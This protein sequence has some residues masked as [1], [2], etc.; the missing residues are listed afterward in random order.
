[1]TDAQPAFDLREFALRA[2]EIAQEN[3]RNDGHLVPVAFIITPTGVEVCDASFEGEEQKAARYA[4][5]VAAAR[6]KDAIAIMTIND[7]HVAKP[8]DVEG[9]Y[10]GK[11]AVEGA[12]ECLWLAVSGPAMET[13]NLRVP[14]Q[15]S[16]EGIVFGEPEEEYGSVNFLPGWP[17]PAGQPS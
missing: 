1:M 4:D 8:D 12:P 5:I 3:L 6:A 10:W 17:G 7:A 2:L 15:R 13:W 9:Y 14:Y 16:A 11:L